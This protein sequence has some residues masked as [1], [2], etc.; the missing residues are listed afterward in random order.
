MSARRDAPPAKRG[1]LAW[2]LWALSVLLVV[3][4][5]MLLVANLPAPDPFA[6]Y[7][8]NLTVTALGFSTVGALIAS[9][10][11]ENPIGWLF[12]AVGFLFAVEW[13][14]GEYSIYALVTN[15][16]SFVGGGFAAWLSAWIWIPAGSLALYLFLLFPGGRLPSPRW[17]V[18]VW[19]AILSVILS[20]AP[21]AF[22]P[23]LLRDLP[24]VRNPF[25]IEGAAGLLMLLE[26]LSNSLLT[27][28]VLAPV[29]ALF[30]RF[31]RAEGVE[32]QQ[33]KWVAYAA[34]I[35]AV[36]ITVVSIWPALDGS[37]LGGAL[38]LL[39]FLA[40]PVAMGIAILRYRL[41][42][43][44]VIINRTL[45]Y[46]AL[47]IALVLIY[48]A[49]VVVLQYALRALT[50]GWSQLVGVASTLAIAAL[51]NPLRRRTQPLIHRRFYRTKNDAV[52]TLDD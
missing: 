49:S 30:V 50:G 45:V 46:G 23:G 26:T 51:F 15:R 39:G 21:Y 20:V 52:K 13:F 5:V 32:R 29:V 37:L 19:L 9:R 4:G 34:A 2:S 22:M 16:A 44:D 1:R 47:S 27:V 25:G 10:R 7:W 8:I 14:A 12:A 3:L 28:I 11:Q 48:L 40:I 24:G 33:I 17:R 43:I 6:P 41:Y 36:A 31:R 42:D 38:F 35:L 18:V